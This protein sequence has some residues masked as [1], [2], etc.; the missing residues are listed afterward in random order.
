MTQKNTKKP[1]TPVPDLK[2]R[3]RRINSFLGKTQSESAKIQKSAVALTELLKTAEKE[4][5]DLVRQL[6]SSPLPEDQEAAEVL[7]KL[8]MSCITNLR[9]SSGVQ[10]ASNQMHNLKNFELIVE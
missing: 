10:G 5:K 8:Q 1:D 4:V 6:R 3:V 7:A 9:L 2:G